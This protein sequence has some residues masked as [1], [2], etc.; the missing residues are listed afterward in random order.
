MQGHAAL[1]L[2][3]HSVAGASAAGLASRS[4]AQVTWNFIAASVRIN[5]QVVAVHGTTGEGSSACTL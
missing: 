5:A 4:S 2:S 1:D 3:C